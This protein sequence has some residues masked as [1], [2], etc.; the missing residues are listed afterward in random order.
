MNAFKELSF[1]EIKKGLYR[2]TGRTRGYRIDETN[3]MLS[4]FRVKFDTE[5]NYTPVAEPQQIETYE[6]LQYLEGERKFWNCGI[7]QEGEKTALNYQN[8]KNAAEQRIQTNFLERIRDAAENGSDPWR[9]PWDNGVGNKAV[10]YVSGKR[11][12][13]INRYNLP[14]GEFVTENQLN[15]IME[16]NPKVRIKR[17]N[18]K[19]VFFMKPF[20]VQKKA[21]KDEDYDYSEDESE[22]FAYIRYMVKMYLVYPISDIEGIESKVLPPY[23]HSESVRLRLFVN[24]VRRYCESSRIR[25]EESLYSDQAYFSKS[26]RS[27]VI[28]NRGYFADMNEFIS[29]VSHEIIHSTMIQLERNVKAGSKEDDEYSKEELVAELGASMICDELMVPECRRQDNSKAYLAHWYQHIRNQ[30]PSYLMSA[31]SKASQA[32]DLVLSYYE[33]EQEMQYLMLLSE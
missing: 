18:S 8:A 23:Q 15:A 20:G 4:I 9:K 16:K 12:T 27:V 17:R 21:D 13:G 29:V 32:A 11:Y 7:K 5:G 19:K 2:K 33:E 26:D 3:G 28:P 30:K 25:M 1:T 31:A 24:M 14:N 10:N 6:L 22:S